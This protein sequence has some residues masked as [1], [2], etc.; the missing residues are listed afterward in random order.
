MATETRTIRW[1][2]RLGNSLKGVV[3]GLILF[4]GAIPLLFWN[5]GNFVK[6]KKTLEEGEATCVSLPSV[7]EVDAAYN[8]K[9]V[10][11]TGTAVTEEELEDDLFHFKKKGIR[12]VRKAEWYQW[13]EKINTRT[14]KTLGGDEVE[15][16]VPS[17][18]K[19][20]CSAPVDS[21]SFMESYAHQNYNFYPE[22]HNTDPKFGRSYA[23][24]VDFGAFRLT[25]SQIKRINGENTVPS[26]NITIPKE[27]IGRAVASG[28]YI[29]I[30]RDSGYPMPQQNAVTPVPAET[31]Q[32]AATLTPIAADCIMKMPVITDGGY[33]NIATIQDENFAVKNIDNVPFIIT[34]EGN[35][36]AILNNSV[37]IQGRTHSA[38]MVVGG[39]NNTLNEEALKSPTYAN[40]K[41]YGSLPVMQIDSSEFVRLPDGNLARLLV[42][43]ET[44]KVSINGTYYNVEISAAPKLKKPDCINTPQQ[45]TQPTTSTPPAMQIPVTVSPGTPQIGDVRLSW[46][47]VG[48]QQT[49]SIIAKQNNNTFAPYVSQE[50][51]KSIDLLEMGEQPAEVM[52]ANAHDANTLVTWLIRIGGWLAMFIGLNMIIKPISVLGD[53]IPIIGTILE[54]GGKLISFVIATAV[55]L[56]VISVAWLFYRPLVSVPLLLI[57]AGLVFWIIKCKRKKLTTPIAENEQSG[58]K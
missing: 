52:F 53:V 10:H 56:V 5:E 11:A 4:L 18:S 47:L 3:V 32:P 7:D 16:R 17:Y 13:V 27:L 22:A 39:N 12:L 30:G 9:L 45:P 14:R 40:I 24:N 44:R 15:E 36:V 46:K 21:A 43:N 31:Q 29:Y 57:A 25:E 33:V 2:E 1:T 20:W 34:P 49:I 51:K 19:K 35:A 38:E 54:Y 48:P 6:T 55:S 42:N 41:D 26:S 58:N 28:N 50:T 8:N 23:E 37:T